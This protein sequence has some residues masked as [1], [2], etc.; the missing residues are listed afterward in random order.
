VTHQCLQWV[1]S[2]GDTFGSVAAEVQRVPIR[3]ALKT[4]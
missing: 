2:M 4:W 1:K 3:E